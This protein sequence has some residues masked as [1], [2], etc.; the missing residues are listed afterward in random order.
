[1]PH[2][3][4]LLGR[5]TLAN[6]HQRGLTSKQWAGWKGYLAAVPLPADRADIMGAYIRGD[7]RA[8]AGGKRVEYGP[9]IPAYG[10]PKRRQKSEAE[11][12]STLIR[13]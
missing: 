6:F 9:L 5:D 11:L 2:P 1:M 12:K 13:D 10:Q 3:D 4:Y 7:V 8:A